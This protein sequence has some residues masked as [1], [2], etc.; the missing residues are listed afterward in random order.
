MNSMK[1]SLKA[2]L[3]CLA[4]MMLAHESQTASDLGS[5]SQFR[6]PNGQGISNA[7]GLPMEFGPDKNVIWKTELPEGHSSP[8]LTDTRIFL[9]AFENEML[10]TLCLDRLSG[11]ILWRKEFKRPRA[12]KLYNYNVPAGPSAATDGTYVFVFFGD[13]GLIAYDVDGNEHWE[14]PLGPFDNFYGMGASPVLADD[15]VIMVCDQGTDS[16]IMAV[17]KESGEMLWKTDRP[18]AKSGHSTPILHQGE[19]GPNQIIVPGSFYLTGYSVETGKKLWWVRGLSSE[20]KSTPVVLD[21]VAYIHGYATPMNQPGRT[22]ELPS[23]EEIL[24]E[25]DVNKDGLLSADEM[26]QSPASRYFEFVDFNADSLLDAPEWEFLKGTMAATNG[27][28][29]IRIGGHGDL[30]DTNILW[31][32][33]RSVPQLPSPLIYQGILYMVND[34]GIVTSFQPETGEVIKQGR[35]K[36]AIDKYFAS[37]VAAD[38]KIYMVSHSGKVAVLKPGGSL[39]L[40]TVNDMGELCFGTPAID[41]GKIYLRTVSTLYCFGLN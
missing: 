3:S 31:S 13:Y 34:G 25:Q 8:V 23:F 21:G 16:F 6:G 4:M 26:P 41:D 5:W 12:E 29:A 20:L 27:M 2:T 24:S 15:K 1:I 7:T 30:T 39:E 35:L 38:N 37:P 10:I 18:E 40:L 17:S 14:M 33:H 9:T 11:E 36:G 28:L 22:I 32:Y 19:E